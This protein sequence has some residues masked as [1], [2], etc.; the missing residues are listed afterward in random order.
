MIAYMII[1]TDAILTA[2]Y[3]REQEFV[4]FEACREHDSVRRDLTSASGNHLRLC[5]AL[6][7]IIVDE[8]D[9]VLMQTRQILCIVDAPLAAY[10][11]LKY[12]KI[13]VLLRCVPADIRR[14]LFGDLLAETLS[15]SDV[16]AAE[17]QLLPQVEIET[18]G[19]HGTRH[20]SHR[21]FE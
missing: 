21:P 5:N 6:D 7:G 13:N 2:N 16:E 4:R 17:D 8:L 10:V 20:P 15:R 19:S 11:G 12:E 14:R 1:K 3:H 9:I 18:V